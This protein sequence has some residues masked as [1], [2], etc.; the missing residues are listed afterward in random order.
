MPVLVRC[1][2]SVCAVPVPVSVRCHCGA[3]VTVVSL[4]CW[5]AAGAV[6]VRICGPGAVA[7]PPLVAHTRT[8]GVPPHPHSLSRASH[9]P[10]PS[11]SEPPPAPPSF[12]PPS[13]LFFPLSLFCFTRV[14]PPPAAFRLPWVLREQYHHPERA[15]RTLFPLSLLPAP[16]CPLCPGLC[17]RRLRTGAA[18]L[19]WGHLQGSTSATICAP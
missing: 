10:H 9:A 3:G 7:G 15:R 1:R 4:W 11:S 19:G 18:G 16:P 6:P 8:H 2:C 5:F 17:H 13:L 14:V 12:P